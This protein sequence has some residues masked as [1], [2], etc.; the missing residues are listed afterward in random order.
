MAGYSA[1]ISPAALPKHKWGNNPQG[2]PCSEME[3]VIESINLMDQSLP[4]L[5]PS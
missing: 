4:S 5:S 3:T 2:F 1:F